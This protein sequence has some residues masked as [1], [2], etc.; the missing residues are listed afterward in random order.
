MLE[1]KA[2]TMEN[3]IEIVIRKLLRQYIDA[4][5]AAGGKV[6][7]RQGWLAER[8]L[9]KALANLPAPDAENFTSYT[10]NVVEFARLAWPPAIRADARDTWASFVEALQDA[11]CAELKAA[12]GKRAGKLPSRLSVALMGL[13]E[14]FDALLE[15]AAADNRP[16]ARPYGP[17]D[18]EI[19]PVTLKA[20]D[21]ETGTKIILR[22]LSDPDGGVAYRVRPDR[23]GTVPAETYT[24][25]E[26]FERFT[27]PSGQ[28][29][30]VIIRKEESND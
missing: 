27:T 23:N 2:D 25:E 4:V 15:F 19:L 11:L 21:R 9:G 6:T 7:N 17:G 24:A 5:N 10:S 18:F 14:Y 29:V 3:S 28:P 16:A 1:K 22:L 13:N 12:P 30:G 26:C 20:V 8:A